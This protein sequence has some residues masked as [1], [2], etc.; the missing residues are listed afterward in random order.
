MVV[1]ATESVADSESIVTMGKARRTRKF[2][3][4]KRL[5]NPKDS[6]LKANADKGAND[7]S[8]TEKAVRRVQQISPALFFKYN[9]A[10]GIRSVRSHL[11]VRLTCYCC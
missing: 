2:A 10:L 6:R 4:V 5:L 7:K 11:S 8:K 9:T 3:Q 1:P